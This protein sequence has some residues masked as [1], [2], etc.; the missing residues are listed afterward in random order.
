MISLIIKD[1]LG[2]Q[3]FEYAYTRYLQYLYTKDGQPED[4]VINTYY[5]DRYDF[6]KASLQNFMLN[7][8]VRFLES[9]EMK[10][11]MD[12]FKRRTILANGFDLIPWKV[13]KTSKPLG[14]EKY[15][16]RSKKGLYYTYSSQTEYQTVLAKA[17]NKFVFGCFQGEANFEPIKDIIRNEFEAKTAPTKENL[18]MLEDIRGVNSVC[19]HIRRGDYLDSKWK[20][21]QIC[22]YEYY[23]RAINQI[24]QKVENPVFFVFSNTHED[25]EW[26]KQNYKFCNNVND[27]ELQLVYVDLD[28]PDYEELRLMKNC[29]HFIISN[30]TFSWWAA[31]LSDAE[32]KIV[33]VPERWNLALENDDSIYLKEWIKVPTK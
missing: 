9:D 13:L 22:T 18:G 29:K 16:K 8:N 15:I 30:S 12:A 24:L 11:N 4:I 28:N 33:L 7:D 6:R 5:I 23:N 17:K 25:I 1:G 20:N 32:E 2:N 26:I 19:L 3:L 27:K 10:A 14:E 31:Y 21:L